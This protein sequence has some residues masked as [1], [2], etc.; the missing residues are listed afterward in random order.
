M[1]EGD[2]GVRGAL[3]KMGRRLRERGA[4]VSRV[5]WHDPRSGTHVTHRREL[6]SSARAASV[7]T[8]R[9]AISMGGGARE[10]GTWQK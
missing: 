5:S 8:A 2:V 4:E 3:C 9:R 7:S 10:S 6:E 1:E